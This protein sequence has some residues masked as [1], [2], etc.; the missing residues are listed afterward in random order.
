VE[1][2]S[3]I[4]PYFKKELSNIVDE[5]EIIS[6][7]Y[8]T[9][10]YLLGYNRSDCIIHANKEITTE[11]TDRIKQ[12]IAD[13]KTKKPIQYI[14]GETEFYGLQFKVN[15]HT[16]IPRPETEELVEWI[17]KEEF[18][19]ALDIGTGSGCIAI[20]LAKNTN[21]KIT[22]IDISKEAID[23]AKEN[24][25]NNKVEIDFML[26]DILQAET[27]SKV[28]LIVSN[29]PYILNSEKEKMEANVLDFEPDLSLFISDN[30]PLLFY[31]KI[32]VL[33]EKSLNCGGKLYFEINEKY[34]AEILEM[35]SKIG[36][37]DIALK[38]DIND[39]DRMVKATKK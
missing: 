29:P 1:K 33:A 5:R 39:K 14:L 4:L 32:G 31:K 21:A 6:W 18:S 36:F 9:I 16:L 19:S 35:L 8:L 10:E 15:E 3:N 28:D 34:G 38:K 23:V 11:I 13:L 30:D 37:V 24:T 22:A 17:L 12:I 27:L 7:A 25:K 26:Q 20:T 2:V